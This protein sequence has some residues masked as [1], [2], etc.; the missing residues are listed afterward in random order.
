MRYS[1]IATYTLVAAVSVVAL[2][3]CTTNGSGSSHG[4]LPIASSDSSKPEV[5]A[6]FLKKL[7]WMAPEARNMNLVYISDQAT[8]DVYA[9]SYPQG[10][11]EGTLTGFQ[12]P[13]GECVDKTGDVFISNFSNNIIEYAH[14][15]TNP[16][17]T[18]SDPN[19]YPSGCSVDPASGNLAVATYQF[20]S[21]GPGTISIYANATGAPTQYK[22]AHIAHMY[23]CGYDDKGNLFVDGTTR[24]GAFAFA[25]LPSGKNAFT[26][27]ALNQPIA[28]PGNVQWDGKYV[29][30]GDQLGSAIYQFAIT[31]NHGTEA[32]A[33]PLTGSGQ[34]V[35][36]WIQSPNVIAPTAN[37][38]TVGIWKYPAGGSPTMTIDGLTDPI[39]ATV[40]L[41]KGKK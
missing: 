21:K 2:A 11:L 22:D 24:S 37:S 8:Q 19:Y 28:S 32:G 14:G 41:A 23:F 15:G 30:V 6:H 10:A 17:A 29:A 39:G 16:I 13:S 31:N 36:F 35:Q 38:S 18:L 34:V 26:N 20:K 27:I 4:I 33:T 25:E 12:Y 1:R 40:S 3:A 7:S 9:Y 5:S